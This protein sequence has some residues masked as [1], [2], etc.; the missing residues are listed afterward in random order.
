MNAAFETGSKAMFRF[1]LI[2][3]EQKGK[4][5]Q[6]IQAVAKDSAKVMTR[7]ISICLDVAQLSSRPIHFLNPVV[8]A[9]LLRLVLSRDGLLAQNGHFKRVT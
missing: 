6:R 5:V 3:G 4:K 2:A 8:I 7:G 9:G 1:V